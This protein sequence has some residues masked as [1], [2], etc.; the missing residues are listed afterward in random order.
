[1]RRTIFLVEDNDAFRESAAF[2]LE[3]LGHTVRAFAAPNDCLAELAGSEASRS[4][5]G[6]LLLDVRLPEMSGLDLMEELRANGVEAPVI[7]MTGHGDVAL[8]VEAMRRGA[9]TFLEKPL[10]PAAIETA[11]RQ[12]FE[13]AAAPPKPAARRSNSDGA[14]S[15]RPAA[16]S[17]EYQSRIDR[18]TAR[19]REVMDLLVAG[20]MN[21]VV[22]HKL[23]ISH[24]TVELHRSRIMT[25][26][27]AVSLPHLLRMALTGDVTRAS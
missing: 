24:K 6:C 25:K 19:E 9:L 21:K 2:W 14:Q 1:M 23:G 18:L 15:A 7:F 4:T 22:A 16:P 3:G 17:P 8:A 5:C 26:M 10:A 12:A 20:C 11:I 27:Q 13:D